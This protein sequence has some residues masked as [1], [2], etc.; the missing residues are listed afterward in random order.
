MNTSRSA[1]KGTQSLCSDAQRHFPRG[2]F[3]QDTLDVGGLGRGSG[4][5]LMDGQGEDPCSK[6]RDQKGV[7]GRRVLRKAARTGEARSRRQTS[8]TGLWGSCRGSPSPDLILK[9]SQGGCPAVL[10]LL[11]PGGG[12]H[13]EPAGPETTDPSSS[14]SVNFRLRHLLPGRVRTKR[15]RG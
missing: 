15:A 8:L 1:R 3:W 13:S 6:G 10:L 14:S 4:V 2:R 12:G 9:A 11:H 5:A 7:T